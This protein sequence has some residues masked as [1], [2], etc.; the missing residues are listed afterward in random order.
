[1]ACDSGGS[2]PAWRCPD[3]RRTRSLAEARS[4]VPWCARRDDT[5]RDGGHHAEGARAR[6]TDVRRQDWRC[7]TRPAAAGAERALRRR[8]WR[9]RDRG[10]AVRHACH[11]ISARAILAPVIERIEVCNV[12]TVI[13][14]M[15]H[16]LSARRDARRAPTLFESPR[17]HRDAS[18]AVMR[19]LT[20]RAPRPR[21]SPADGAIRIAALCFA[22]GSAGFG[23]REGVHQLKG[24][25]EV[26]ARRRIRRRDRSIGGAE[27]G[28]GQANRLVEVGR[29]RSFLVLCGPRRAVR[30]A[31]HGDCR[32]RWPDRL[33]RLIS[34][35]VFSRAGSANAM[36]P[37][38]VSGAISATPGAAR[39]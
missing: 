11:R 17:R 21:L 23:L 34:G 24:L 30:A 33:Q 1:M 14:S 12:A 4:S 26:R 39:L 20:I 8:A 3:V 13:A 6:S 10:I 27:A 28:G 36:Y 29:T 25:V 7:R 9:R 32:E 15:T 18:A 2:P 35:V 5:R 31:E 19:P 16:V 22:K 38:G 37:R